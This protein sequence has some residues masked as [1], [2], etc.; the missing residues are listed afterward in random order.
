MKVGGAA[1]TTP[2]NDEV[3]GELLADEQ[4]SSLHLKGS[5]IL[6]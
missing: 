6:R 3:Q 2:E 4:D 5:K 1:T